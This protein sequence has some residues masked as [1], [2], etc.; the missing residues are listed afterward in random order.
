M[1][2]NPYIN[3]NGIFWFGI[4]IGNNIKNLKRKFYKWIERYINP[5]KS[6][7]QI[8]D[9]SFTL[10]GKK[11]ITFVNKYSPS[12]AYFYLRYF[13]IWSDMKI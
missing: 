3:K 10:T 2:G 4:V 1:F 6:V 7:R 13:T 9:Q 8:F 5:M 12:I 11:I